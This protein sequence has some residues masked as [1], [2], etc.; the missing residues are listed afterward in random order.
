MVPRDI[1][2]FDYPPR[3]KDILCEANCVSNVGFDQSPP[4]VVV[5]FLAILLELR[6]RPNDVLERFLYRGEILLILR[7]KI[8]THF[9]VSEHSS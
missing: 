5:G 8:G 3:L 7:S 6:E 1:L 2:I 4:T 9:A